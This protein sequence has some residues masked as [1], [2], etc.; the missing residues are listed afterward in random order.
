MK[1]YIS[2]LIGLVLATVASIGGLVL[3]R[4]DDGRSSV[5]MAKRPDGSVVMVTAW[6]AGPRIDHPFI[7][8][9]DDGERGQTILESSGTTDATTTIFTVGGLNSGYTD[10]VQEPLPQDQLLIAYNRGKPDSVLPR[11]GYPSAATLFRVDGLPVSR[12]KLPEQ[13][14]VGNNRVVPLSELVDQRC[15]P[16]GHDLA[17]R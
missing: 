9:W 10:A 16:H 6:C 17:A 11:Q 7:A 15:S 8:T 3:W 4:T 1:R 2:L 5:G 13:V 14:V 12:A